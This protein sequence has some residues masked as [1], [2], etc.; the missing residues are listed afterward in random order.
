MTG[1]EYKLRSNESKATEDQ[2]KN[3]EKEIRDDLMKYI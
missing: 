1:I 3:Y 2:I